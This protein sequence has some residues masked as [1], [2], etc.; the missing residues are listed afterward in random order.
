MNASEYS[1]RVG[2]SDNCS[3][4]S[5]PAFQRVQSTLVAVLN[6]HLGKF[7][8]SHVVPSSS[9]LDLL[10]A[11]MIEL[12]ELHPTFGKEARKERARRAMQL[13]SRYVKPPGQPGASEGIIKKDSHSSKGSEEDVGKHPNTQEVQDNAES[14]SKLQEAKNLLAGILKRE[15]NGSAAAAAANGKS[16]DAPEHNASQESSMSG[17][18]GLE[19][20]AVVRYGNTQ[21][22][23]TNLLAQA[24]RKTQDSENNSLKEEK[25]GN[26]ALSSVVQ[27]IKDAL[28]S[29]TVNDALLQQ[30]LA[31]TVHSRKRKDRTEDDVAVRALMA[32][33]DATQETPSNVVA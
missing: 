10:N 29:E 18:S 32:L 24:I 28:Q 21:H 30:T 31:S 19:E 33:N 16:R 22:R 5:A 12:L 6:T 7:R 25:P 4:G 15:L 2:I 1:K 9:E 26:T 3:I 23:I 27:Q 13:A 17:S 14:S 8:M 11:Q 20:D